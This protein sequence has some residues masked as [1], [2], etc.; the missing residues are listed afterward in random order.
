[1]ADKVID[2]LA[3]KQVRSYDKEI[4]THGCFH[5]GPISSPLSTTAR[6]A[7]EGSSNLIGPI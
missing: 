6:G 7:V 4:I 1:M 3:N 2:S 5:I